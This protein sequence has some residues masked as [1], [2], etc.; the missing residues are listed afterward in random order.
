MSE[1]PSGPDSIGP[2]VTNA[3]R[4]VLEAIRA[5]IRFVEHQAGK[6]AL[7]RGSHELLPEETLDAIREHTWARASSPTRSSST[8]GARA[9]L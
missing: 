6:T 9:N 2:E 4:S 1:L 7:N 3:V 8:S 5:P